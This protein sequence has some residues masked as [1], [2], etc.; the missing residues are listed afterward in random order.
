MLELVPL[1]SAVFEIVQVPDLGTALQELFVVVLVLQESQDLLARLL[2]L[3]EVLLRVLL[4]VALNIDLP[5]GEASYLLEHQLVDLLHPV[6]DLQKLFPVSY[7]V[8]D[9]QPDCVAHYEG[10]AIRSD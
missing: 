5:D 4:E 10:K 7:L 9:G 3:V 6:V 8:F 1:H 2:G